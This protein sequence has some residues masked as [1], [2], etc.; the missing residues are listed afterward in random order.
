V[1]WH[2]FDAPFAVAAW[3]GPPGS[4]GFAPNLSV[5]HTAG[6]SPRGDELALEVVENLLA[7]LD[8]RRLIDVHLAAAD[9]LRLVV[10]HRA[11]DHR[12]TLFQRQLVHEDGSVTVSVTVPDLQV[13]ALTDTWAL[14]LRTLTRQE[15]AA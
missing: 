12:L 5:V 15:V 10:T 13:A 9:D 4:D 3:R 8:E 11:G 2:A 7:H 1:G 6:R 14:P